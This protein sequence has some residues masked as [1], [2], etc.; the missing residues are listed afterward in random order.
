MNDMGGDVPPPTHLLAP[1]WPVCGVV[2]WI[3]IDRSVFRVVVG[4]LLH[5][6]CETLVLPFIGLVSL[7]LYLCGIWLH[8]QTT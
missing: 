1:Q 8:G 5:I 2:A 6:W 4:T 7:R 3:I